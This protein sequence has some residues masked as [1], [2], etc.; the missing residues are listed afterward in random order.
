[1]YSGIAVAVLI[2]AALCIAG[3]G[4]GNLF[5]G[6]NVILHDNPYFMLHKPR[7]LAQFMWLYTRMKQHLVF[8]I[9]IFIIFLGG[10]CCSAGGKRA[11]IFSPR[12]RSISLLA[13]LFATI[14]YVLILTMR[15]VPTTKTAYTDVESA[16]FFLPAALMPFLPQGK[17]RLGWALLG[18]IWLPCAIS[19]AMFALSNQSGVLNRLYLLYGGAMLSILFF[20]M[21]LKGEATQ[22]KT[23]FIACQAGFIVLS[24]SLLVSACIQQYMYVYRDEPYHQLTH[25]VE[26]GVYQNLYTTK[27][28]AEAIIELENNIRKITTNKDEVLFM[29]VV[30]MAYLMSDASFCT[31]ST[32]D[33][34]LYTYG[35]TAD[36]IMRKYFSLV[37][38]TPTK[39][40][41]IY[42]G[43][44]KRLSI[45]TENYAFNDFVFTN[46]RLAYEKSTLPFRIKMFEKR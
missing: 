7:L 29:E 40:I 10:I 44:D 9:L 8:L 33:M 11:S 2:V 28:R 1:M 13:L 15:H 36:T 21:A 26:S 12:L 35:F 37:K 16:L 31:P 18:C 25:R 38:K 43:R 5:R 42:T 39:M 45:E 3:G 34:M 17:R 4:F 14:A 19:L 41:Y 46:Y 27:E 30:P 6:V 23:Y 22:N 32:W 20:S 24:V